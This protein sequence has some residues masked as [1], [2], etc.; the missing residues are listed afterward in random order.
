MQEGNRPPRTSGTT[1]LK[2]KKVVYIRRFFFIFE[3]RGGDLVYQ[4]F[5][6]QENDI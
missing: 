5:F 3:L 2:R 1:H 6:T 4:Y